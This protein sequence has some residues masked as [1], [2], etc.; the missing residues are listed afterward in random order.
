MQLLWLATCA[1]WAN[2]SSELQCLS[3]EPPQADLDAAPAAVQ[4]YHVSRLAADLRDFLDALDL[5]VSPPKGIA[6]RRASQRLSI[7]LSCSSVGT[8]VVTHR[9]R[10]LAAER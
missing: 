7:A 10:I 4:G 5:Q 8:C 6:R 3:G 2:P 9:G 1:R